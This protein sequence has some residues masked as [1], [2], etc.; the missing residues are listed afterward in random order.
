MIDYNLTSWL[1]MNGSFQINNQTNDYP[2]G[3][4][5]CVS[6]VV[7]SIYLLSIV[8][9]LILIITIYQ[10]KKFH[11]PSFILSANMAVADTTLLLS[12]NL[13]S[14]FSII[15]IARPHIII[16]NIHIL[17]QLNF[18]GFN[19]A[20]TIS[21]LSFMIISIDRYFIICLRNGPTSPLSKKLIL[22]VVIVLTWLIA[23]GTSIPVLYMADSNSS[24]MCML[25][26]FTTLSAT[27]I[28]LHSINLSIAY[29]IPLLTVT[30]LYY[31]TISRLK[32]SLMPFNHSNNH[33]QVHAT[34]M[35][36]IATLIYM[37]NATFLYV[38]WIVM[39]TLNLP[40]ATF[41]YGSQALLIAIGA[42]IV[43]TIMGTMQNSVLFYCYNKNF[44]K[45]VHRLFAIK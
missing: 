21:S 27:L 20:Y 9:N 12:A 3:Y 11:S 30:I 33:R 44:R 42:I 35:M 37:I 4:L 5:L 29:L 31:R 41:F 18:Y 14:I 16:G 8:A 43:I 6:I 25:K 15:Q 13:Y 23:F 38:N 7:L 32:N 2:L 10:N 1:N 36:I 22:K 26:T 17:C 40:V 19:S 24:Y 28:I 45:A 34:K 39:G